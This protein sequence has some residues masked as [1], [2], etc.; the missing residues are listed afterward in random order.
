MCAILLA[1]SMTTEEWVV[2]EDDFKKGLWLT[3]TQ[4]LIWLKYVQAFMLASL[5]MSILAN[6][7]IVVAFIRDHHCLLNTITILTCFASSLLTGSIFIYRDYNDWTNQKNA[8]FGISMH[9]AMA[10]MIC[11]YLLLLTLVYVYICGS[12]HV[13]PLHL[14]HLPAVEDGNDANTDLS[15]LREYGT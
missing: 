11:S 4:N 5:S 2:G 13:T 14:T 12:G 9:V 3:V 1:V 10:A 8:T 6:I 15:T 7:L